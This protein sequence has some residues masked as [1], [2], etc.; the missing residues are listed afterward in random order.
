MITTYISIDLETTGLNPKTDKITEIGA[1]KV[2]EGKITDTFRTF[3]RPGKL[4]DEKIR[5]LTGI[6]NEDLADA[7]QIE[8]VMH[9]VLPFL[10]ELPLLGHR[11]MF[12]YAFLKKAAVNAGFSFEKQGI[13]TLKLARKFLPE[14][15]S[16]KLEDLCEYFEIPHTAH[17]ALEDAKATHLL[18]TRL[19]EKFY[20]EKEFSPLPLLY[21]V[22]KEGP[23]T[24]QQK[25]WLYELINRHN[26]KVDYD[27][28]MLTKNEASR[29]TD[30]ILAKYGR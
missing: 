21:K 7:P 11:V 5:K 26:L 4:L 9:T 10:E 8:P 29:Y 18:Y 14:L 17:R 6:T 12:D 3:V 16:R 13:D 25:E 2:V 20:T 15:E 22:K 27:V 24:K 28:E 1:V 30:I 23:V 19:A